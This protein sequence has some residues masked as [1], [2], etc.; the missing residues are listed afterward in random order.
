MKILYY[1]RIRFKWKKYCRSAYWRRRCVVRLLLTDWGAV[2][3]LSQYPYTYRML[4]M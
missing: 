1:E 4:F 2:P 3:I